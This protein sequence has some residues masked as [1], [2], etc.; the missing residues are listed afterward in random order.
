MLRIR[1][2][3]RDERERVL[4]LLHEWI[5]R[6]FFRRYFD[7]DPAFRDDLAIVAEDDGRFVATLQILPKTVRI[8]AAEV[9]VGGIGNVFTTAE[10]RHKGVASDVLRRAVEVLEQ[11]RFDLSLLFASRLTFYAQFG[12]HSHRR[13]L[14]GVSPPAEIAPP[15][16]RVRVFDGPRDL[17]AVMELYDSYS[18]GRS[19]SVVRD[20]TYWRGQLRYAGNPGETFLLAERGGRIVAYVRF[21]D[22]YNVYNVMEHAAAEGEEE[23]LLDLLAEA[24]SRARDRG[25]FL[26]HLGAQPE[27]AAGLEAR[28]F[29][30]NEVEDVF[31]MWRVVS[32]DAL[33]EKLHMGVSQLESPQLFERLFPYHGSVYWTSDRF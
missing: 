4:E 21:V 13:L 8:G 32:P 5:S 7:H 2:I 27:L 31:W 24:G 22:L 11:E 3:R 23:A 28:G 25:F 9:R 6:D 20:Q 16:V 19:G 1:T 33:A 17:P 10:Y 12:W 26:L 18:A 14:A 30:V 29:G 15:R